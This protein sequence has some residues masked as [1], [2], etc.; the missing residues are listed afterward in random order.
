M[1]YDIHMEDG[2][3]VTDR[4]VGLGLDPLGIELGRADAH[5][6]RPRRRGGPAAARDLRRRRARMGRRQ[7]P[8]LPARLPPPALRL[9]LRLA[10]ARLRG[11]ERGLLR[12]LRP[13]DRPVRRRLGAAALDARPHEGPHERAAAPAVGARAADRRAT[14]R[15]RGRPSS[16]SWSRSSATT[17]TATCAR[18]ARSAATWS[19]PPAPWWS[20]ATIRSP[21]RRSPTGSYEDL[22]RNL[23]AMGRVGSLRCLRCAGS[24][25]F[26]PSSSPSPWS[27]PR[28]PAWSWSPAATARP[29]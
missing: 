24:R 18:C 15:T 19:R 21:G 1:A 6:Q 2:W 14:P 28:T 9:R 8:G 22:T 25:P 17:C 12:L 20:A 4:L 10:R 11:G 26:S 23:W 7:R 5:A 27:P 16:R 13:H 29:R 3:A